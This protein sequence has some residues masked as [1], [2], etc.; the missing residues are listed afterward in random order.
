MKKLSRWIAVG[1]VLWIGCSVGLMFGIQWIENREVHSRLS[2]LDSLRVRKN[3]ATRMIFELERYRGMSAR[4]RSMSV[5]DIKEVKSQL[6]GEISGGLAQLEGLA[7][8]GMKSEEDE[9]LFVQTGSQFSDFLLMTAKI[10]PQLYSRDVFQ[11]EEV[12]SLHQAVIENLDRLVTETEMQEKAIPPAIDRA[13]QRYL[14]WMSEVAG[15][16]ILLFLMM[17]LRDYFRYARPF[18]RLLNYVQQIKDFY[19]EDSPDANNPSEHQPVFRGAYQ[20]VAETLSRFAY[21]LV[22]YRKERQQFVMAVAADLRVPLVALRNGTELLLADEPRLEP[23]QK[24][25]A[26][27][28]VRN[29]L[30]RLNRHLEDL[31]DIVELERDTLSLDEKVVDLGRLLE[32][33]AAKLGGPHSS[34][35]IILSL[36]SAPVWAFLDPVRIERALIHLI[37][38][39]TLQSPQGGQIHGIIGRLNLEKGGFKGVEIILREKSPGGHTYPTGPNLDVLKHWVCENGFGITLSHRII[40]AHGGNLSA[41]GLLGS[42][43]QFS[44]RIPEERIATGVIS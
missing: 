40:R 20:T 37:N 34:H 44:I 7:Q 36:P 5:N 42:G 1:L 3:I 32:K 30:F 26:M 21:A 28:M 18:N 39:I 6:K 35:P 25:K 43:L 27:D 31:T 8:S 24:L 10:E 19:R 15:S 38:K 4:F 23:A 13:A 17:G 22:R 14:R 41:A 33:L 12:R 16:I 2:L 29:S 11:K 9:T